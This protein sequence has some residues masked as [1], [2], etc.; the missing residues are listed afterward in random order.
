MIGPHSI[1]LSI[2]EAKVLLL[3][4]KLFGKY[5][6]EV[7]RCSKFQKKMTELGAWD[8]FTDMQDAV[9]QADEIVRGSAAGIA[10]E[11]D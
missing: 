2:D 1:T 6:N 4:L 10:R 3:A 9:W 8:V 11:Y 5:K 7:A